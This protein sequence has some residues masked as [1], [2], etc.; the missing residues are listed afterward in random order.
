MIQ[1]TEAEKIDTFTVDCKCFYKTPINNIMLHGIPPTGKTC[2]IYKI[3]FN[4]HFYI[5]QSFNILSRIST[6]VRNINSHYNHVSSKITIAKKITDYLDRDKSVNSISVHLL[7]ACGIFNLATA[8]Y[9]WLR[10]YILDNKCL[11]SVYDM[12]HSPSFFKNPIKIGSQELK[13]DLATKEQIKLYKKFLVDLK[14]LKK[15]NL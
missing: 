1:H 4:E 15:N 3:C 6:H 5:G 8:E 11:N 13:F 10:K 2:G 7:E 12:R 14:Y 9:R